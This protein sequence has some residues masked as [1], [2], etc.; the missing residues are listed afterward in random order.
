MLPRRIFQFLIIYFLGLAVLLAV[1][2]AL[3]LSN[4]VIPGPFLIWQTFQA[5]AVRYLTASRT[6]SPRK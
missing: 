6:A 2:Y 1:K 4:Y 5:E 3:Q